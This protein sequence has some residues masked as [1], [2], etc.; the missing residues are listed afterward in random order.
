MLAAKFPRWPA[1]LLALVF[2]LFSLTACPM[3]SLPRNMNLK[4]FDPHRADFVCKHEAEA[5]PPITPEAEA[6]FQQGMAATSYELIWP[7]D[8]R[9][10]AKAAQLW[11]QAVTLGHWKAEMNL[12][13][14]YEQG[15]GVER[16]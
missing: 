11:Q 7:Q 14:L 5:N 13:G 9:D 15:L 1:L 12:A 16:D 2:A 10:Y 8:K 3:N 6:L 4:A